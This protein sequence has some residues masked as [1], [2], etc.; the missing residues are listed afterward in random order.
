M[1]I[2]KFFKFL[3]FVLFSLAVGI[4]EASLSLLKSLKEYFGK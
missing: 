1:I 4:A 2:I 3:L